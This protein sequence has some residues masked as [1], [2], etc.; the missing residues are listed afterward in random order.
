MKERIQRNIIAI[1]PSY[2]DALGNATRL[3]L[4]EDEETLKITARTFINNLCKH[5]HLDMK[6][7]NKHFG[8]LLSVRSNIPLVFSRQLIYIKLKVREPIGKDDGA[9]GYFKLCD[10]KKI[11]ETRGVTTI[12][13]KNN[14]EISLLCSVNTAQK[15]IR[16]GKLVMELLSKDYTIKVKEDLD[17]YNQDD[18]PA[19]KSDIAR[20]YMK[21][22]DIISKI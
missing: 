13:M 1:I 20:L 17:S 9:M 11:I 2:E 5:Y 8:D 15:Q 3:I 10:I 7:S 19:M 21:L 6:A 4:S 12:R 16:Q 14:S 18:G 22:D